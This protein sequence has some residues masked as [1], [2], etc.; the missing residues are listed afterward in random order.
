M[1]GQLKNPFTWIEIYVD[2]MARA[3]KFYETVL[4]IEM[5]PMDTPGDNPGLEMLSFPFDHEGENISGALC[6]MDGMEAGSGGTLV[7]FTC[8]DCAVEA[9]RV[10]AAGGSIIQPKMPIGE[11]GHCAIVMDTEGN[12]IGLHSNN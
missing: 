2:D 4:Q 11:H 6:K 1:S 9:G 5:I 12:S 10:E 8:D 7:Y 3:R